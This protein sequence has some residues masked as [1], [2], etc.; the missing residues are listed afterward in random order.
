MSDAVPQV[1]NRHWYHKTGVPSEARY[2]GRGTVLGNPFTVREHGAEEALRRY[3][4]WLW[5]KIRDGDPAVLAEMR[6]ITPDTLLMCSCA[7]RPCHGDV[8]ARAW[9]WMHDR[10]MLEPR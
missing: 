6:E 1:V 10:G 4:R 2:I 7:P 8:V 5:D 3:R 9:K